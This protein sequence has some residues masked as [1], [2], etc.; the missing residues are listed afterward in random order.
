MIFG[1]DNNN[2]NPIYI[3]FNQNVKLISHLITAL[4]PRRRSIGQRSG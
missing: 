2:N 1:V 3:A 4:M